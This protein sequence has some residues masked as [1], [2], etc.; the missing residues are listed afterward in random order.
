MINKNNNYF[1][2]IIGTF[3]ILCAGFF[4][5]SSFN[6][7]RIS[8]DGGY[9]LLAKFDNVNGIAG[10]SDVK[11]SGVKIG[12]VIEQFIDEKTFRATIKFSIN[13]KIKLPSDSSAKIV[14]DGL[15]GSKF[16]EIN[17]GSQDDL[18]NEGDELVFTQSSVNFEDLLARFMFSEKKKNE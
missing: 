8:N 13:D 10:G 6:S 11:I 5:L 14:S 2:F 1:D 7:T 16:L 4:F 15:L 17:P 9:F 18:L 3:V 12:N